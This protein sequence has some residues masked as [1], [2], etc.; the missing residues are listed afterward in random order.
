MTKKKTAK[1]KAGAYSMREVNKSIKDVPKSIQSY[2][3]DLEEQIS[4]MTEIGLALSKEKDMDVLLEMILL[5]AKRIANSDGGTLY[6][7]TDDNRLA[8]KIMMTDSL[9]F[10]MGGTSGVDIPFYP[11]K[12]YLD[13]GK[14]NNNMIA[15]YVGLTGE[16]VNIPDAYEAEGFD[17]S[18]TRAFDE[19]TG[20]RSKSFLTVP[21]R[22]HED[23]IIGVLQLLN[24]QDRKTGDVIAFSQKVQDLVE[25][26]SSQAAVA[27]TNKNL[28][29]DLEDLFESFIQ[30]IAA[31]I[32]AKSKYTGG[33]CQRIP[34]LTEAIGKA[35]NECKDGPLADV[36][37]DEDSMRELMISAW[38]HDTGKVAT[39][40]HVV[41]KS[42]KLETILDRVHLVN[43][44]FEIIKRDEEIKFLKKQLKVAKEGKT[45]EVKELRKKHRANLKQIDDDKDFINTVNVG[46][47][48]LSPDKQERVRDV[49]KRKWKDG[50]E[51]KPFLSDEEVYNLSISRG[52]LTAEDRKIINDHTV[53]TINMLEKLP[54]PNKL[55]NVPLYAGAHHEK[56][57]GTGYPKGLS[58]QE[59]PI[60]PRIVALA[61]VFEALTA[62]DRPYKDGKTV[63]DTLRI[64]GFMKN[65]SHID[66][67]L[68][69]LFLKE[70]VWEPY[71]KEYLDDYQLDVE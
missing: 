23:E 26:L 4:H 5:E 66:P 18:G 16:T 32:D 6:M 42:T 21:L 46:G 20:Y 71:S 8:F 56:P 48:F 54:W 39:P 10:H 60:Q 55:K 41:D 3:H 65:D 45:D 2:I 14:P 44:R 24:A 61:D 13:D 25:A 37:F 57:D 35:V 12:L 1:P 64:M 62:K 63:S 40:V 49:A 9:D 29:K 28:I 38:L 68:F 67:F 52:T 33:H 50:K 17:F 11:I 27:I 22:D 34:L 59:L 15:A 58:G 7:K 70:R 36:Y 31:A 19:K 30:M 69:E 47:E 53:H 43:T 51:L